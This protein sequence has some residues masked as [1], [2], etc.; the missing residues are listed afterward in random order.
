MFSKSGF[1]YNDTNYTNEI[2]KMDE[3]IKESDNEICSIVDENNTN[4]FLRVDIINLFMES[5]EI[6]S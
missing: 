4:D 2:E 1:T 6:R 3:H 5:G